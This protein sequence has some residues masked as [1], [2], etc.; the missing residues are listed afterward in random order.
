MLQ[1]P[2]TVPQGTTPL[3]GTP[4]GSDIVSQD[5]GTTN[6]AE[7]SSTEET[8]NGG[9]QGENYEGKLEESTHIAS[10]EDTERGVDVQVVD[11]EQETSGQRETL[12]DRSDQPT[13]RVTRSKG[14][15]NAIQLGPRDIQIKV[16][17][18]AWKSRKPPTIND[19][20]LGDEDEK[21]E[22]RRHIGHTDYHSDE[23]SPKARVEVRKRLFTSSP[24][25]Q[26]EISRRKPA[27]STGTSDVATGSSVRQ[28]L[29]SRK[30][31]EA[32]RQVTVTKSTTSGDSSN[33]GEN[34]T[35]GT[36]GNNETNQI[37]RLSDRGG[38]NSASAPEIAAAEVVGKSRD[39]QDTE[40]NAWVLGILEAL[41]TGVVD[42]A[43]ATALLEIGGGGHPRTRNCEW[44]EGSVRRQ[45]ETST[46]Q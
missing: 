37:D 2:F 40:V 3:G 4:A 45:P 6:S 44:T 16:T 43:E 26:A 22:P 25:L 28:P 27:D 38:R 17:E 41:L 24:S 20:T 12:P 31:E 11:K 36:G 42:L 19:L 23:G 21:S 30:I 35:Q 33:K 18:R 34:R 8:A 14:P 7:Q 5:S 39:L 10:Q 13:G 1:A 15:A 32:N 29:G 9:A 46:I